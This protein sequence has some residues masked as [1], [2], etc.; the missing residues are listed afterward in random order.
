[1]ANIHACRPRIPLLRL[2][3]EDYFAERYHACVPVI[4]AQLDGLVNE[5]SPRVN[6]HARRGFFAEGSNLEAWDSISAHSNGLARLVQVLREDRRKTTR[7]AVSI[8]FRNGILH[9]CDLGYSNKLAAC[10]REAGFPPRGT[11]YP[12]VS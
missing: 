7:E 8:P 11:C 9:G 1:M 5:L 4:L 2:A 10:R 12:R 3:A 6:N